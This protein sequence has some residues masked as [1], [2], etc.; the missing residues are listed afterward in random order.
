MVK[1]YFM[2]IEEIKKR[3]QKVSKITFSKHFYEK[4]KLRKITTKEILENL[5]NPVKLVAV[6]DQGI[7]ELGHKYALLFSKSRKYD[8]KIVISIK[9]KKLNVVTSYVQNKKRRKVYEKW[10]GKLR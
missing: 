4:A 7:E 8:L 2:E 9:N 1:N 3:L 5:R 10:L 6:E